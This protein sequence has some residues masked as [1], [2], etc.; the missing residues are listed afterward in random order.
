MILGPSV[1]RHAHSMDNHTDRFE[2]SA[3]V[4]EMFDVLVVSQADNVL[5]CWI[6][7]FWLDD[8]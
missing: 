4:V 7:H 2:L 6:A 3:V 1:W 8:G 5:P